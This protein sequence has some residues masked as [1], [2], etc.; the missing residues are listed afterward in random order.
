MTLGDSLSN[1]P[2]I[3]DSTT[4]MEK[5]VKRFKSVHNGPKSQKSLVPC[6]VVNRLF[7]E[8]VDLRIQSYS[9]GIVNEVLNHQTIVEIH[10]DL[11][12]FF[13]KGEYLLE[14]MQR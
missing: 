14:T 9:D 10:E 3:N 11:R 6:P 8:L 4:D 2:R 1:D 12:K 7:A 13:S 5:I